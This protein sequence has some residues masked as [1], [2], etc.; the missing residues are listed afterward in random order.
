MKHWFVRS[1]FTPAKPLFCL[2]ILFMTLAFSFTTQFCINLLYRSFCV[3]TLCI[4]EAALSWLLLWISGF[5][6]ICLCF[7]DPSL[8][9]HTALS[10]C[11][12]LFL[13]VCKIYVVFLL[14]IFFLSR[15]NF[16]TECFTE[17][18]QR[19]LSPHT[20]AVQWQTSQTSVF[21]GLTS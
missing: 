15:V 2:Y 5:S 14:S 20:L 21:P 12:G 3:L 19:Q 7:V 10:L 9:F 4:L 6:F 17:T 13:L 16:M 18:T 11:L 8:L 1:S